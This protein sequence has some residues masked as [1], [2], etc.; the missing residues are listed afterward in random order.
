[1][2]NLCT[3]FRGNKMWNRILYLTPLIAPKILDKEGVAVN[4]V[5]CLPSNYA[6]EPEKPKNI[7]FSP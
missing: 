5:F 4:T 3:Q 7:I 2:N 1:M 6:S